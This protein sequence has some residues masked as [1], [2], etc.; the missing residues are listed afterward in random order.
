MRW[1]LDEYERQ[2]TDTNCRNTLPTAI[3]QSPLFFLWQT[4]RVAPDRRGE[5]KVGTCP[6]TK[7]FTNFVSGVNRWLAW[8]GDGHNI[9]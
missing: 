3:R 9:A 7:T 4:R 1:L 6:A 8:I 2:D 5:I